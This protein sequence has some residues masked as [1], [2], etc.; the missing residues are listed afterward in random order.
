VPSNPPNPAFAQR[1]DLRIGQ[2]DL[3]QH[4]VGVVAERAAR[5]RMVPGVADSLG[6]MPG[7]S[8]S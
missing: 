1:R 6:T 4:G 7:T 3:A 5:L 2:P 8:T